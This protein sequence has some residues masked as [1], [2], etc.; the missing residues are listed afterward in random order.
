MGQL[1]RKEHTYYSES[2]DC[3]YGSAQAHI[4]AFEVR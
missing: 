2:V 1:L 4:F 3:T